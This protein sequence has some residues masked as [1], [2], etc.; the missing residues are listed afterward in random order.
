M[1]P[2]RWLPATRAARIEAFR[3]RDFGSLAT[4]GRKRAVAQ[5]GRLSL[6][7]LAAW[8]LWSAAH[9]Y[10]LIGFRNRFTV[11][12]N[13][14]WGYITFQRGSRLITG[15]HARPLDDMSRMPRMKMVSK[16]S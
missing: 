6:S 1:S 7:G 4:I 12:L 15:L 3:Y 5:M 14:I 11:I 9:I 10:F 16:A 2:A 8:L 13:W